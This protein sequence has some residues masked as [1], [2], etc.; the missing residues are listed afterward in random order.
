MGRKNR[1][2]W[3]LALRRIF[4]IKGGRFG[5]DV[6]LPDIGGVAHDPRHHHNGDASSGGH[7]HHGGG[8]SGAGHHGG[9][10]G[11]GHFGGGHSG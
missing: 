5:G 4:S 3:W 1:P 7:H 2:R 8:H 11:G 10:F 6:G 9:H